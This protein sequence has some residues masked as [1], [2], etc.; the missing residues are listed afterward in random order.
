MSSHE[1]LSD[2]LRTTSEKIRTIV[3]DGN[4]ISVI[5]HIDADGLTSGSIIGSALS[6]LGARFSVRAISDMNSSVIERMKAESRDFT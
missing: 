3:E 1:K 4:E 2:A 6:R 5:T